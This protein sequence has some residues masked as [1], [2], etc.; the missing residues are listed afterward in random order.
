M[1]PAAGPVAAEDPAPA[2]DSAAAQDP[3]ERA[4]QICLRQLSVRPRTRA[5]L[6]DAL[7]RHG[8]DDEVARAVLDRYHE[9]GMI[10]DAAFARAWVTSR[11]EQK[12]LAGRA[13]GR[14]LRQRGVDPETVDE[15]VSALAP[16]AEEETARALVARKLRTTSGDPATVVRRLVGMLARKGYPP[17]L[18]Y[19]VVREV[20]AADPRT[21]AYAEGFDAEG[22]AD[23]AE[24]EGHT[25]AE[26]RADS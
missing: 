3:A 18:A 23:V 20:T 5:E 14:E 25:D 26:G 15:A 11:H 9:V 16:E 17:G 21:S 1:A 4:R 8:I 22:L 12:G 24:A 19:R 7:R 6:A 10:D 13:L 2:E